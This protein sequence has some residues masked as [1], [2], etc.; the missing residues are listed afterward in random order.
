MR[1]GAWSGHK[2]EQQPAGVHNGEG[3][4][5][6]WCGEGMQVLSLLVLFVRAFASTKVQILTPEEVQC[7][8][9]MGGEGMGY[10]V[11]CASACERT[12]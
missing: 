2:K 8:E 10:G 4:G 11:W 3:H 6:E 9:G 5:E 1:E 7:A 12:D